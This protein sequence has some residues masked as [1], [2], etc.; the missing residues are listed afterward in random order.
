MAEVRDPAPDPIA[1]AITTRRR[2]IAAFAALG[3]ALVLGILFV[4]LAGSDRV[5][6]NETAATPLLDKAAPVVM[7]ATLDGTTFDLSRRRGNWVVLN[8]FQSSCVPCVN[9]HPELVKFAQQQSTLE[10]GAELV[11][12]IWSDRPAN[13]QAF[14]DENG[15]DWPVVI[16]DDG[17]FAFD[18]GVAQ[19]PE[20]WVID[21]NGRVVVHYIGQITADGLSAKLQELR[22]L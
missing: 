20:T 5:T 7:G 17:R 11:S 10:N 9:E 4:V 22:S 13:V 2:P 3:A 16:D 6:G 14:F 15:G 19:V 8:F 12:I 21:P 1:D 18:Y